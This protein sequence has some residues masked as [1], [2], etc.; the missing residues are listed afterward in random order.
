MLI[1][2]LW[3]MFLLY[4]GFD[5]VIDTNVSQV[6]LSSRFQINDDIHINGHTVSIFIGCFYNV[7]LTSAMRYNY[8]VRYGHVD[9]R[10]HEF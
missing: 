10:C 7:S 6:F 8:Y 4:K 5:E 3:Y 2:N 1:Y 9:M